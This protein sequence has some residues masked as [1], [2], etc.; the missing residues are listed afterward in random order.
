[1]E[2]WYFDE[3][4]RILGAIDSGEQPIVSD[5]LSDEIMTFQQEIDKEMSQNRIIWRQLVDE[6]TLWLKKENLIDSLKI[7]GSFETELDL[8]WSDID[9]VVEGIY[10]D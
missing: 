9:L 7:Y 8:P 10:G 4:T 3:K 1:M 6:L 2:Y 5:L